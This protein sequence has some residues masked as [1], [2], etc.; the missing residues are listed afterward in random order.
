MMKKI[1]E[2]HRAKKKIVHSEP[3]FLGFVVLNDA[4]ERKLEFC[5]K[6]YATKDCPRQRDGEMD[7]DSFYMALTENSLFECFSNM[8]NNTNG[9]KWCFL[10]QTKK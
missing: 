3:I 4:K 6:N 10:S 8:K 5:L 7:T 1:Y 9:R 2:I